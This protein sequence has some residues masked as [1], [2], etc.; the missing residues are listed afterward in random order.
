MGLQSWTRLRDRT[1][2][3]LR[4][5]SVTTQWYPE[6]AFLWLIHHELLCSNSSRIIFGPNKMSNS[7]T[8]LRTMG[9]W[10]SSPVWG[11]DGLLTVLIQPLSQ[12]PS[13]KHPSHSF[14]RVLSS[15]SSPSTISVLFQEHPEGPFPWLSLTLRKSGK[16]FF[17][18][19]E[20]GR[21]EGWGE[22]GWR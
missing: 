15:S 20:S 8:P 5:V 11:D 19:G 9:S 18:F 6:I 3:S 17:P 22:K 2:R 16:N 12:P 7:S 13:A 1:T 4:E 21:A 14:S 10:G